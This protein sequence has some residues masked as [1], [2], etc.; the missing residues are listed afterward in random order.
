MLKSIMGTYGVGFNGQKQMPN[1]MQRNAVKRKILLR[2]KIGM[3]GKGGC[4]CPGKKC[5]CGGQMSPVL[6]QKLENFLAGIRGRS[7]LKGGNRKYKMKGGKE[8]DDYEDDD[9]SALPSTPNVR[10]EQKNVNIQKEAADRM[11]NYLVNVKY[12]SPNSLV[13]G[14]NNKYGSHIKKNP[15]MAKVYG[16]GMRNYGVMGGR[17]RR[18]V[19]IN[20]GRKKKKSKMPPFEK[21]I[22]KK[23]IEYQSLWDDS[24]DPESK[25]FLNKN[26]SPFNEKNQIILYDWIYEENESLE[27]GDDENFLEMSEEGPTAEQQKYRDKYSFV[28]DY[29]IVPYYAW[30]FFKSKKGGSLYMDD[31]DVMGSYNI[32][33]GSKIV[34]RLLPRTGKKYKKLKG[35]VDSA[36][37]KQL[38]R[39]AF[40]KLD[41]NEKKQRI[42]YKMNKGI[43][44][45]KQEQKYY[46]GPMVSNE[47]ED[48][49]ELKEVIEEKGVPD[50]PVE[51]VID[52]KDYED[53]EDYDRLESD[54]KKLGLI[55]D[56]DSKDLIGM[57]EKEL[58]VTDGP[59]QMG[60]E[61]LDK[62][63][64][65]K[66]LKECDIVCE[67]DFEKK[68]LKKRKLTDYNK[69]AQYALPKLRGEPNRMKK[70]GE[71][72]KNAGRD[73]AAAKAELKAELG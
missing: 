65:K 36:F 53:E 46:S 62:Y 42:K 38:L 25:P 19:T 6:E 40:G 1:R 56:E 60:D 29:G 7:T 16:Q 17:R 31:D 39:K 68:M 48:I 72:W 41:A 66:L 59:V 2:E 14:V 4:N 12:K 27:S 73:L 21:Y 47:F 63:Q 58:G 8:N 64:V 11:R 37:S 51:L 67:K 26:I 10:E 70:L 44:L 34:L 45:Q 24:D 23:L 69:F 13:G 30:K 50:E 43:S 35:G 54:L 5:I 22:M 18:R 20:I 52:M 28:G 3:Y 71:L 9:V 32:R 55:L 61:K 15:Y 33:G 49:E 57:I